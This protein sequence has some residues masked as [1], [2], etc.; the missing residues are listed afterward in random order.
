MGW[1]LC[2]IGMSLGVCAIGAIECRGLL[3]A[4]FQW[5]LCVVKVPSGTHT[6]SRLCN[7]YKHH[8]KL[9]GTTV[10]LWASLLWTIP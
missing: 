4:L 2:F 10:A 9:L 7:K 5:L 8:L 1:V 3:N 6:S